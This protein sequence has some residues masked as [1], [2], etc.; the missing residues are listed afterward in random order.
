MPFDIFI[1]DNFHYMDESE[2]I[3]RGSFDTFEEALAEAR[4]IVETSVRSSY[5]PGMSFNE[6]W[7]QYKTFGDDPFISSGGFSAWSYAAEVVRNLV[8]A[9]TTERLK[10][11]G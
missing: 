8:A 11:N 1:D 6:L 9:Q 3:H 2:R 10:S 7:E 4:R 5:R